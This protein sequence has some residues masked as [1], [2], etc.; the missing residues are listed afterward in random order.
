[1]DRK[2]S[3]FFPMGGQFLSHVFCI[4]KKKLGIDFRNTG[5][6]E[7]DGGIYPFKS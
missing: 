4:V 3:E 6:A 1:M 2:I 5:M 7:K